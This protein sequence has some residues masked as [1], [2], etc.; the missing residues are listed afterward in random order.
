[1][2]G[3]SAVKKLL[4]ITI[5]IILCYFAGCS[6]DTLNRNTGTDTDLLSEKTSLTSS[7]T[8]NQSAAETAMLTREMDYTYFLEVL[9]DSGF[10]YRLIET[11]SAENGFLSVEQKVVLVADTEIQF[12]E[13]DYE[14]MMVYEYSSTELMESDSENI[15]SDGYSIYNQYTGTISYITWVQSPYFFKKDLIIVN[16][17]G[18]NER[19]IGFLKDTFGDVFAGHGYK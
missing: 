9:R 6:H 3:E 4:V 11:T 15:G 12:S 1:V 19:I 14:R 17:V 10:H 7:E 2:E 16:Y 8:A 18:D 13:T 5:S